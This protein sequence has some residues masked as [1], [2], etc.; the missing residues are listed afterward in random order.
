V[1][2][3]RKLTTQYASRHLLREALNTAGLPFE[4]VLPGETERH[5]YGYHGDERPE[6]ATFI[7]RRAN[8]GSASNDLGFHWNPETK[9][10]EEIVSEFDSTHYRTTQI[11]KAVKREYAAGYAISQAKAKGYR[12]QRVDGEAGTIQIK[13]TGRL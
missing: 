2:E 5:L 12:T 8:I 10:F 9:R 11:R 1:S 4:E 7:V 3:Y 6:T 13:I